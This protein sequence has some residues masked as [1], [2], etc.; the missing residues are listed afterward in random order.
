MSGAVVFDLEFTA[1]AGSMETR[2]LR[3]GEFREVVQIGAVLVDGGSFA[4]TARLDLLV[5]PR[6]NPALSAYFETLTGITN[7]AVAARGMDFSMAYR[8][9]VDF[10]AGRPI[11]SFGRDDL[12]LLDNLQLYGLEPDPP[13]PPALNFVPWLR[14]QGFSTARLHACDVAAL[15]GAAFEGRRHDALDDARSVALGIA[16]LMRRGAPSPLA[17][18]RP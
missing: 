1:W 6:L 10:A 15:A 13:L 5:K 12:V 16:A 11:L 7:E 8:G 9:F 14:I 2:W 17:A 4:E 18:P 3:P